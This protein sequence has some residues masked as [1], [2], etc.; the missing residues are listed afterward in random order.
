MPTTT[1][2]DVP[3]TTQTIPGFGGVFNDP[4]SEYHEYVP[5]FDDTFLPNPGYEVPY[6]RASNVAA[7]HP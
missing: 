7:S 6:P 1:S 5:G 3:L 2:K 4:G